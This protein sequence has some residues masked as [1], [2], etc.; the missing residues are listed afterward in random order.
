M[1]NELWEN[2]KK[3]AKI[4]NIDIKDTNKENAGVFI[5]LDGNKVK[6]NDLSENEIF[7]KV[8]CFDNYNLNYSSLVV[9][10]KNNN[11]NILNINNTNKC[12]HFYNENGKVA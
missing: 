7:D 8:F 11:K 4:Y 10:D 6:I 12:S 3:V 2:I 9:D 1:N 5:E